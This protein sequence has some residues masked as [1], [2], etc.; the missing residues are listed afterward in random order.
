MGKNFG[1]RSQKILKEA[2]TH[3]SYVNESKLKGLKDNEELEFLGDAV[4]GLVVSDYLYRTYPQYSCGDLSKL[5]SIVVSEPILVRRAKILGIGKY[6]RLGKGE[7]K[8]GGR[9]RSSILSDGLEAVIGALY[10]DCGLE[11][12]RRFI[13]KEFKNEINFVIEEKY[14]QDHKGLL[15]EI[16]QARHKRKP[17]Y[18]VTSA[19]GPQHKK[20]FTVEVRVGTRTMGKG[21]GKSK[22]EAEQMAAQQA[23]RKIRR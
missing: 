10:L 19:K 15:Q 23:I 9:K 22:K 12:A 16:V 2:L 14:L 7:E 18:K 11:A 3:S 13:L 20:T 17:A 6:L 5:K 21:Q 1:I 4:L 8:A